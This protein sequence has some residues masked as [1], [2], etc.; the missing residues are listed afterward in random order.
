MQPQLTVLMAVHNGV[1]YLHTAIDSILRQTYQDFR[2]LIVDDASTDTTRDIVR[3][4]EDSRIDLL[5]LERNLG[6]TGA[7]NAGLKQI[8]TPWI[9]RMD[10]DDFSAPSRLQEQMELLDSDPSLRCVG[11]HAWTFKDDPAVIEGVIT[12]PSDD[13]EIQQEL[14]RGSPIIHG[15]IVVSREALVEIGAYNERY[16]FANDVELYDRLL[17]KHRSANIPNQLL[18]IR[19]HEE[20]GSRTKA[21]FDEVIEIFENRLLHQS[22]SR[23]EATVVRST[24]SRFHVVRARFSLIERNCPEVARD[25]IKAF[26]A[27]PVRFLWNCIFVFAVYQMAERSRARVKKLLRRLPKISSLKTIIVV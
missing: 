24:L 19:R 16:R 1:P 14:L 21:S 18:G 13:T 15:S 22:Y 11:T 10:A 7:L 2:F 5:C 27:S 9:A 8:S 6:Q 12:K 23:S 25:L 4:Y 20:Q 26:R 17:A 3:S